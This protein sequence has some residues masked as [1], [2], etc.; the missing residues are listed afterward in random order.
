MYHKISEHN[1]FILF[2]Y[3]NCFPSNRRPHGSNRSHSLRNSMLF[4]I[5]LKSV[6]RTKARAAESRAT[7]MN[8]HVFVDSFQTMSSRK[9]AY[10][11]SLLA[12]WA[13]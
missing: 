5:C 8:V 9:N 13:E 6:G 3:F 11:Q 7:N 12:K 4:N 1:L 2:I 10:G